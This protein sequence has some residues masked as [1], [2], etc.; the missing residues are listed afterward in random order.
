MDISIN[1]PVV[2]MAG[3]RGTRLMP[4]TNIL[5][6]PLLSIGDNPMVEHVINR[7]YGYGCRRFYMLVNYKKDEIK[8]YFSEKKYDYSLEIIVEEQAL[9]TG[10]GLSLLK[11]K[12]CETFILVNCDTLIE[13]E[14]N[15]VYQQHRSSGSLITMVCALKNFKVPYGVV[16]ANEQ[17]VVQSVR[18][19]PNMD[20]LVNTGCYFAEPRVI[21]E[22]EDD[23]PIDFTDVIQ[24][25]MGRGERIGMCPVSD[26]IDLGQPDGIEQ[27]MKKLSSN[28]EEQF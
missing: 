27:M 1:V 13:G 4:Y 11:D 28:E 3:G 25:Y 15:K 16:E 21:Q 10:G 7:L 17:G 9:G 23:H 6:K 22:M 8:T 5:P 12:V 19:K 26:W 20:F 18:E 2:I 14:F 24:S